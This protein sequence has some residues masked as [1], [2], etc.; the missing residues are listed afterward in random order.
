MDFEVSFDLQQFKCYP[1]PGIKLGVG[2]SFMFLFTRSL[3]LFLQYILSNKIVEIKEFICELFESFS[4]SSIVTA[5]LPALQLFHLFG[6]FKFG[7]PRL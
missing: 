5:L 4:Y 1:V 7:F 6:I 3:C 2:R